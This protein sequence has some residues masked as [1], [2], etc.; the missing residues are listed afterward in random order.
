MPEL[1]KGHHVALWQTLPVTQS[2]SEKKSVSSKSLKDYYQIQNFRSHRF[3]ALFWPCTFIVIALPCT[4]AICI[5]P[6][7]AQRRRTNFMQE[8][9]RSS[10]CCNQ[11]KRA[12]SKDVILSEYSRVNIG[13][14]YGLFKLTTDVVS[15]FGSLLADFWKNIPIDLHTPFTF[16]NISLSAWG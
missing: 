7:W 12:S 6:F 14:G 13:E 3:L 4:S 1:I 8:D 11:Q 5:N 2:P 9:W 10:A 15:Y 16:G